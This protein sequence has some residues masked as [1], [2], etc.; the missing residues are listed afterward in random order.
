MKREQAQ[1]EQRPEYIVSLFF[2]RDKNA[3][4]RRYNLPTVND[5]AMI[6]QNPDGK[7]PFHRDFKVYP[8]NEDVPLINLNILSPNIDPMTYT[9][10][11]PFGK[12][13]WQP[14][15]EVNDRQGRNLCRRNVTMLQD[16]ISQTAIRGG[17]F[18]PLLHGGKLFQQWI[19]NSYLQVEANNLNFIK[20][21]QNQ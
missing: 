2:N 18:N 7:P 1:R 14:M 13:G 15:M 3:D 19:V 5:I 21:Q 16:K 11:F 10:F 20:T 9:L 17:E 6:F 8:R 4:S 12:P